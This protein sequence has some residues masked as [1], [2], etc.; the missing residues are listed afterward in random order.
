[1]SKT[2]IQELDKQIKTV[3]KRK[4]ELEN[5]L[6]ISTETTG[7]L[8]SLVS[9]KAPQNNSHILLL[10]TEPNVDSIPKGWKLLNVKDFLN[11]DE[12]RQDFL[13]F[14]EEWPKK[15]IWGEKTFDDLFKV[16]GRYSLWWIGP[17]TGRHP[18][19]EP[20]LTLRNL[21]IID[22]VIRK[23][24]P[25]KI[26]IYSSNKELITCLSSRLK[27]DKISFMVV[28]GDLSLSSGA[29][30][31]QKIWKANFHWLL[32]SMYRAFLFPIQWILTACFIRRTTGTNRPKR[33][34]NDSPAIVFSSQV[35]SYTK[36]QD[37]QLSV[38]FWKELENQL[39]QKANFLQHHYYIRPEGNEYTNAVS[40]AKCRQE[41][42]KLKR[43]SG[44]WNINQRYL[45]LDALLLSLPKYLLILFRYFLLEKHPKFRSSFHFAGADI[46]N[47]YVHQLRIAVE[48]SLIWNHKVSCTKKCLR[49]YG[50]VKAMLVTEE[51]YPTALPELAASKE[52]RIPTVGIQH[53]TIFPMH[54][55]Y[56][57]P[58]G[59]V[60]YAPIPD[61]FAAYGEFAKE[62]LTQVGN[63]PSERVWI[64]GSFRFDHLVNRPISNINAKKTLSLPINQIMILMTTQ[65]YPWFDEAAKSLF[66]ITL[67]IPNCITCLKPHPRDPNPERFQEF[68][69][70]VGNNKVQLVNHLFEEVVFGCDVLISASSTTLFEAVLIGKPTICINYSEEPD[71]Y[72]YVNNGASISARSKNEL[73]TAL[74][75]CLFINSER[76]TIDRIR[77]LDY[78]AGPSKFGKASEV[79]TSKIIENCL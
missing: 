5:I 74:Q 71:R 4:N 19:Y 35:R 55:I 31:K 61:F 32:T 17:G 66:E 70:S 54:L 63:Y 16:R 25:D 47:M 75:H 7:E 8:H 3:R 48:S 27:K 64:T 24:T 37:D 40:I 68:A 52:L 72:P 77:F 67:S 23:I 59:Y 10:G 36:F 50:N 69:K 11:V 51:F 21:W 73:Q 1:M 12:L 28:S 20:F 49:D 39:H 22:R 18:D 26:F 6:F 45:A 58:L 15:K 46:S 33:D 65:L 38:W 42:R 43:I 34:K 78:H 79:L 30:F 60:R 62:T 9:D 14:L 76:P 13:N 57:P 2:I 56:T 53:G 29:E 44:S 41:F